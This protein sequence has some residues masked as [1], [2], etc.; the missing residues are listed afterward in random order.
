MEAIRGIPVAP[1]VV[2]GRAFIFE[3]V[4]TKIPMHSIPASEVPGELARL[5][6]VWNDVLAAVERD[7][8]HAAER[9]GDEPA[10]IFAFHIGLLGDPSLV[11]PIRAMIRDQ[12]LAAT[13][14]VSEGFRALAERFRGLDGEV[15]KEKAHDVMD[16]DKRILARLLGNERDRLAAV[17]EPVI[18]VA[19]E[20][21]PAEAANMDTSKVLALAVDA[22]G[23]T[24]HTAIVAG[25]LGIP[26]VVG[27]KRLSEKANDGDR[28]I[29]DGHSGTVVI[30]PDAATREQFE[31]SMQKM[32][33]YAARVRE[34]AELE[35]V[36][37]DG[38]RIKL[39]G[40]IEFA[41]EAREIVA[42]GGDGVGLFRTEFLYLTA[43]RE[44]TEQEHYDEYRTCIEDLAGRP[45]TIRTVDLGADKYTQEQAE[46]P[47]RNPMLGLRSIRYC[48]QNLGMFRTQLRAILRASA[49]GPVRVMFPLISTANELKQARMI[50]SD[51]MEELRE[52]GVDFD[53]SLD[54]GMMIEVPSAAL[55]AS[56]FAREVSFFSIGTND[57]IQYTLAVDR[58]N[59]S[60]ANLYS[61]SHP[62]VIQLVKAIIR[63]GRRF[64]V[65]TSLCGE[66]AAEP[67]YTMLLIGLGLRTLSLVPG[68][69]PA[70][71]RVVRSV[72]VASC[73]RLARKVGSFDSERQVVKTLRQELEKVIPGTEDAWVLGTRT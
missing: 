53:A 14:A 50:L 70:I 24:G 69:I 67:I 15:F 55:L 27:C 33:D 65:D 38:T 60:V 47:E 31:A 45:L 16:L 11:E 57:L 3:D 42:R 32:A 59:A 66:M 40:N 63:A 17:T 22:G 54:V 41:R 7:R 44:P 30:N 62:A 9:L 37:L 43:G 71:K 73:E 12:R 46:E 51:V 10:K 18:V 21:T 48:L 56:T 13:Y 49:H 36:T 35:S 64:E 8:D 58:G 20:L 4:R 34:T 61:G 28:L 72:D 6:A 5:E 39:M 23:R 68:Q 29:V 19:H 1:G 26:V 52:E 2:F 25:A